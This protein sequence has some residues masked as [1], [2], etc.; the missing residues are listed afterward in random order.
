M[1]QIEKAYAPNT[2]MAIVD[3]AFPE[4]SPEARL[5]VENDVFGPN[6]TRQAQIRNLLAKPTSTLEQ[7]RIQQQDVNDALR[8][9]LFKKETK[10][11]KLSPQARSIQKGG[12]LGFTNWGEAGE[13]S[14]LSTAVRN[15]DISKGFGMSLGIP[16]K[17][18]ALS[19]A[20]KTVLLE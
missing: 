3:E 18:G 10:R 8:E 12:Q 20:W 14:E 4:L 2:V 9:A 13:L 5:L 7:S 11:T 15:I 6:P 1:L 19:M 17:P 16:A